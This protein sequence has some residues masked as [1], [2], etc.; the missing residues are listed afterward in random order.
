MDKVVNVRNLPKSGAEG[1]PT[2]WAAAARKI[3]EA[4]YLFFVRSE[5]A[6]MMKSLRDSGYQSDMLPDTVVSF[7]IWSKDDLAKARK[8]VKDAMTKNIDPNRS[9]F[10]VNGF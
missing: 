9:E 5:R 10:V 7:N 8:W 2:F 3:P 1:A 4:A 6:R